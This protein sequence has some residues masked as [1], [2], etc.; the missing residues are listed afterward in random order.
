MRSGVQNNL[1]AD[2]SSNMS[3]SAN[4]Q[5]VLVSLLAKR[6]MGGGTH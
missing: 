6:R 5:V 4:L 2:N 3:P 1:G